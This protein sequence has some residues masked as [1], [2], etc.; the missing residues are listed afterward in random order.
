M[1]F[2]DVLLIPNN[3]GKKLKIPKPNTVTENNE[4]NKNEYEHKTLVN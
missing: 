3:M 4:I 1:V 2:E